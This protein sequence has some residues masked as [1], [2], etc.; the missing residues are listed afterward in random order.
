M[1]GNRN[2]DVDTNHSFRWAILMLEMCDK[3]GLWLASIGDDG[4]DSFWYKVEGRYHHDG[5]RKK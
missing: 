3:S 5:C 4:G 2:P 1:S